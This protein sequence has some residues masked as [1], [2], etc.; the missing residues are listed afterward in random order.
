LLSWAA[1]ASGDVFGL[2]DL[3]WSLGDVPAGIASWLD[4]PV[5]LIASVQAVRGALQ[6]H[7]RI[8]PVPELLALLHE[9]WQS[10]PDPAALAESVSR[11]L[12]PWQPFTPPGEDPLETLSNESM[13][14]P[15]GRG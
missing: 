10:C 11:A 14:E 15:S 7:R 13:P 3:C 2:P 9:H 12:P 8:P 6:A 5:V 4:D 1:E